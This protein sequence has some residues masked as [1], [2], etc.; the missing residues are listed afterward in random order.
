[1]DQQGVTLTRIEDN[2][3]E[4]QFNTKEM[5]NELKKALMNEK[6]LKQRFKEGDFSLNCLVF[7]FGFVVIMS[8][9]DF[10]LNGPDVLTT[11][12]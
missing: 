12:N 6:S 1:V 8:I 4:S 7:L 11:P 10:L 3:A 5:H 9:I 2:V